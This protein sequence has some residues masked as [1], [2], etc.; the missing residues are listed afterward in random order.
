MRPHLALA[1]YLLLVFLGGA[2]L[3]PWLYEAVQWAGANF[4]WAQSLA[5]Q[6]FHRFVSRSLLGLALLGLWP[7]SRTLG[8]RSWRDLGLKWE[9]ADG[10]RL[11]AGLVVGF[12][13]L[14]VVAGIAVVVGARQFDTD[15]TVASVLRHIGGA[16]V[17]ATVVSLLEETVFRGALFGGL[18][19]AGSW[20]AALAA[21]STVYALVHFFD[22]PE[23]PAAVN[24]LSGWVTLGGMCRGFVDGER[25]VPGFFN[26]ALA[27]VILGLAYHRTG[28]L[29]FSI[30]LH[31]GWVFW[32]KSYG[33][34]TTATAAGGAWVWG[35][36]R[37]IDG[38][39]A[40]VVLAGTLYVCARWML[41][42]LSTKGKAQAE[43]G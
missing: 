21:S 14:A 8:L 4:A 42:A 11:G 12:A 6:P 18:R 10:R 30:G 25:L 41:P 20:K 17:S 31:A 29:A 35:T 16:A 19:R 37:L 7:L 26:L 27:G 34:L 2:L 43:G 32:L 36:R 13:S 22:K 33:F 40:G 28:S 38:W 39:L 9:A 3:A 15:R 23:S 1:G 5:D 24:W